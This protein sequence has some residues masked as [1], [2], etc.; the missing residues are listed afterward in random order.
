MSFID[1]GGIMKKLI[2]SHPPWKIVLVI[3][4]SSVTVSVLLSPLLEIAIGGDEFSKTATIVGIIAFLASFT[5]G[6]P[7]SIVFRNIILENISII[8]KLEKDALTG[9]FNR[10]NFMKLYQEK[11]NMLKNIAPI[12]LVMIDIDNFKMINDT[13]GHLAGDSVLQD[14]GKKIKNAVRESDLLCRFGG[15]EFIV[16]LWDLDEKTANDIGQRILISL[17]TETDCERGKIDYTVSVGL[18]YE[19]ICSGEYENLIHLA[20]TNMYRAKSNGKNCM[21]SSVL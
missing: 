12:A 20:D 5:V 10:H 9:L 14:V 21:I 15:E 1:Y 3:V 16:V 6:T 4:I 17:R 11:I 19:S 7:I 18:V 8:E 13:Y 2:I